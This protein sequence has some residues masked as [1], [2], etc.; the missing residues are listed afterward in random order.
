MTFFPPFHFAVITTAP[1]DS[2]N[3]HKAD[4]PSLAL[5]HF[6][7]LTLQLVRQSILGVIWDS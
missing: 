7:L 4:G 5:G 2:E 3:I 6:F 1:W